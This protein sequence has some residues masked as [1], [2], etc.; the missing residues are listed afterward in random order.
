MTVM[1]VRFLGQDGPGW[2]L[3]GVVTGAGAAPESTDQWAY[4]LRMLSWLLSPVAVRPPRAPRSW[5]DGPWSPA[6]VLTQDRPDRM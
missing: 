1:Q 2:L 6:L 3:R 5:L 4:R